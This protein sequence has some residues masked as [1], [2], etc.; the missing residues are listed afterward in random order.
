MNHLASQEK[1]K[2][3]INVEE[4]VYEEQLKKALVIGEKSGFVSNFNPNENLKM[5]HAKVL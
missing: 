3:K 2:K 1:N 4:K 5:I